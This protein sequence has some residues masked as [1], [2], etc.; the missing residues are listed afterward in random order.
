MPSLEGFLVSSLE[1]RQVVHLETVQLFGNRH[2]TFD[3]SPSKQGTSYQNHHSYL[4][5]VRAD[6]E[7]SIQVDRT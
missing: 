2:L 1:I 5:Y 7:I 3:Y 6:R 4:M